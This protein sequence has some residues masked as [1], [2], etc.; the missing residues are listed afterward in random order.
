MSV[1]IPEPVEAFGQTK[2][3]VTP[4]VASETAPSLASDINGAS[5]VEA[6]FFLRDFAPTAAQTKGAGPRVLGTKGQA[7]RLGTV[8]YDIPTLR[9]VYNPQGDPTD[10][11]NLL[12]EALTP[13]T[14]MFIIERKGLD[15]E[16]VDWTV[17]QKVRV[18]HVRL[19]EYN[20]TRSGDDE[21]AEYEVS[22]EVVYVTNAGPTDGAIAA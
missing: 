2:V 1:L 15:A 5:A 11:A 12:K 8:T 20:E 22:Q 13:G 21:F 9:Y 4:T 14:E 7:Q 6:S 3:V 10:E 19:G 17:G 16:D 18:H